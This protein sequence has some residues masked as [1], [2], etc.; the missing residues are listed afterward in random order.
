[1]FTFLS[2]YDNHGHVICMGNLGGVF[3]CENTPE[4]CTETHKSK[5]FPYKQVSGK[6]SDHEWFRMTN[7]FILCDL[8]WKVQKVMQRTE[9]IALISDTTLNTYNIPDD[10]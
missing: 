10:L 7:A 2:S 3:S 5:Y 9:K 8:L 4:D 6:N 1:M